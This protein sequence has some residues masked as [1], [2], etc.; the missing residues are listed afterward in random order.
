M[1]M[2]DKTCLITGATS[3]IG[4]VTAIQLARLGARIIILA[5][6]KEK[7]EHTTREIM[8]YTGNI[9]IDTVIA[10]LSSIAQIHDA[11]KYINDN[12]SHI[13]VLLNNAGFISGR[14]REMTVD[15]LE[16]TFEV[17]YLSSFLLTYLLF[18][19]LSASPDARIINVS[20]AAHAAAK[21]DFD[22]LQMERKYSSITAYGNSKLYLLLFTRQLAKRLKEHRNITVNALHPGF[23]ASN[24]SQSAGGLLHLVF[25]AFSF[26]A[27]S[28]KR[29]AETSIYL[30]S[31]PD[32][33]NYNG[34]YFMKKKP[35][36]VR[37]QYLTE[38]NERLLWMKSEQLTD[39][40]FL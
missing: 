19:K 23:V 38:E 10:D 3:G 2:K 39:V 32:A 4:K 26:L 16:E 8:K 35:F 37:N 1:E 17:N 21:P 36:P 33:I 34:L 12:Y 29:G 14:T 13:D 25:R 15:G 24:F 27:I 5:R 9:E 28:P 40:H 18:D 6:N 22:D 7:A 11:A 30:A 31:S 20:S